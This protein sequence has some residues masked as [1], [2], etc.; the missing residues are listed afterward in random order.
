VTAAQAGA[1][2]LAHLPF[3]RQLTGGFVA[4]MARHGTFV[5]PTLTMLESFCQHRGGAD[6]ACD[7]RVATRLDAAA[8]EGLCQVMSPPAAAGYAVDNA[9]AGVPALLAAG[10]D[11]L[12][13]TDAGAPGTTHGASLHRELELLVAAGMRPEQA[14]AAATSVP[15]RRMGMADRGRIARGLRADLL[16][17]RGD[18][19]TDITST[20]DIVMVCW[21]GRPAP[22]V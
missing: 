14:L 15:A 8:R 4:E 22:R 18:P 21:E 16:V 10:V 17:V 12:A 13:G 19:V 11:V 2:G 1:D 9:L 3:D 7:P 20:R 6:L 5:I